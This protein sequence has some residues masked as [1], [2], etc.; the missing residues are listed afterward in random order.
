MRTE[1]RYKETV[2]LAY[3]DKLDFHRRAT[4]HHPKYNKRKGKKNEIILVTGEC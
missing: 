2:K 4:N 1:K 3:Q